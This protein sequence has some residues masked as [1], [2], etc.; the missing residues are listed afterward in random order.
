LIPVNARQRYFR[1]DRNTYV[2][3]RGRVSA[4]KQIVFDQHNANHNGYENDCDVCSG[5]NFFRE[6]I[7]ADTPIVKGIE[8]HGDTFT[9]K[10]N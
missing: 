1:P 4:S 7:Q 2:A 8:K 6:L 10:S 9:K 3:W 5:F